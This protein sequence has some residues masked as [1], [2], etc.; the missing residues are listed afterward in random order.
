MFIFGFCLGDFLGSYVHYMDFVHMITENG[1][2]ALTLVS[3][4]SVCLYVN[5]FR[6]A[7]GTI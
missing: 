5:I 6:N 7:L 2:R 4:H 1:F 3:L